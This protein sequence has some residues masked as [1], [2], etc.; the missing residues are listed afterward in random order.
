MSDARTADVAA[1]VRLIDER[2]RH[3]AAESVSLLE[4]GGRVLAR[5]VVSAA[6]VPG[7]RRAT[8]DGYAVRAEETPCTLRV[9]GASAPGRA[10]DAAV[11]PGT[12][13]RILTGAPLPEG[14]DAVVAEEDAEQEG[15]TVRVRAASAPGRNVG[16]VGEDIRSG[17]L[18]LRAGRRLKPQDV[19]VIASIGLKTAYCVRR[20]RVAIL[21]TG[22]ELLPAGERPTGFKIADA[23]SPTLV[24]L[25][26]RDGGTPL[27]GPIVP[28]DRELVREALSVSIREADCILATGGA[29]VS[30]K[31]HLPALVEELG[32][33]PVRGVAIRPSRLTSVGFVSGKPVFLLPGNSA[34]C[35]CAYDFFAGRAVRLLGGRHAEWPYTKVRLP[36]AQEI[37]SQPGRTD[38]VRVRIEEGKVTPL[39][40]RGAASLS[41]TSRAHGFVVV[42]RDVEGCAEGEPVSVFLY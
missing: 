20:P 13:V 17:S 11:A 37:A 1:V 29:S 24:D 23:N 3:L 32:E 14:A 19:G 34:G 38:Y 39:A 42:E 4:A 30:A 26:R 5:D 28:D 35:L 2:V 36:L 10:P 16:E 15:E 9:A 7:F 18:L 6:D 22:D 25:V 21:V 33:L 8:M 12:C 40:I 41:S 27:T 31:D